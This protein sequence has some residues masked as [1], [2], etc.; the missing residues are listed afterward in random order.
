VISEFAGGITEVQA[1]A[2]K[3]RPVSVNDNVGAVGTSIDQIDRG[4]LLGPSPINE[5]ALI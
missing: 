4:K 2:Q 5:K 3:S 1:T